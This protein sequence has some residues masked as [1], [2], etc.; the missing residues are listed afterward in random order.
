ML[1]IPTSQRN[2]GGG[3]TAGAGGSGSTT[4]LFERRGER[5]HLKD[6]RAYNNIVLKDKNIMLVTMK[7][8]VKNLFHGPQPVMLEMCC[9]R[10]LAALI[11]VV[12][13]NT[14]NLVPTLKKNKERKKERKKSANDIKTVS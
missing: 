14:V 1:A 5:G 7:H 10:Q 11:H 4:S 12:F 6:V 2:N 8:L 13:V 3:W 9:E